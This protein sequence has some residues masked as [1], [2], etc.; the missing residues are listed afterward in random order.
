MTKEIRN[1]LEA[2][3]QEFD[4]EFTTLKD[5]AN[6]LEIEIREEVLITGVGVKKTVSN[7]GVSFVK[8]RVSWD[9]KALEGYAAAH[10]EIDK[11]KKIGKPSV[12][13]T[14]GNKI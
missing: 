4:K 1:Q 11:F 9:T 10:S 12:R 2:V 7:Y 14:R 3:D 6:K 13:I 5:I 8:G